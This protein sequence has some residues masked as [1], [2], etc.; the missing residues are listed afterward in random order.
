MKRVV[1]TAGAAKQMRKL[2]PGVAQRIRAKL[3]AYAAGTSADVAVYRS[4]ENGFRLRI[5]DWRAIFVET[6]ADI[7]VRLVG[8]RREVYD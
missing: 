2:D 5:G 8:H 7:V 3:D 6:D 4:L 1:I